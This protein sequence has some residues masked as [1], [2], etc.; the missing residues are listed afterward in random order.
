[1]TLAEILNNW[2]PD[3]PF[4]LRLLGWVGPNDDGNYFS[5]DGEMRLSYDHKEELQ[6]DYDAWI[7]TQNDI[8]A[9]IS[10]PENVL[11]NF[12]YLADR[13]V[14]PIDPVYAGSTMQTQDTINWYNA[15]YKTN[16]KT[17][18]DYLFYLYNGGSVEFDSRIGNAFM[19]PN[20][21]PINITANPAL[22]YFNDTN[23]FMDFVMAAGIAFGAAYSFSQF[24]PAL[25]ESATSLTT[26][27]AETAAT[28]A[29]TSGAELAT[30]VESGTA[31]VEGAFL[32]TAALSDAT[33]AYSTVTGDLLSMTLSTGEVISY[34]AFS[35]T[36]SAPDLTQNVSEPTTNT[37]DISTPDLTQNPIDSIQSS[38]ED[39]FQSPLDGDIPQIDTGPSYQDVVKDIAQTATKIPG[40]SIPMPSLSQITGAGMSLFKFAQQALGTQT[41]KSGTPVALNASGKPIDAYGNLAHTSSILPLILIAGGALLLTS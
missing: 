34:D 35:S 40:T 5:S 27:V 18:I 21:T 29:T 6:Y 32:E 13:G 14:I 7:P 39:S 10:N 17:P 1:M 33:V 38:T 2:K 8:K 26:A 24:M 36:Y 31:G 15:T 20:N 41:P 22:T 19:T 25:T 12:Q 23:E 3:F 9:F 4:Y 30:L 16:F 11:N 37:T 28:T